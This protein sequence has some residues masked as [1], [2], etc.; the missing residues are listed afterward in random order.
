MDMAGYGHIVPEQVCFPRQYEPDLAQRIAGKLGANDDDKVVLKLCNR[1]RAAGVLVVPVDELDEV[2]EEILVLPANP[3]AWFKE[4]LKQLA[5]SPAGDFGFQW[6]SFEEQTRHWWA[7]EC[8][9]FVAERW[10]TSM[11]TI[12]EG[13]AYDGTMRVG[14]ALRRKSAKHGS[15]D[16]VPGDK[17]LDGSGR[18]AAEIV[19]PPEELEVE[20]LGGYWKLPKSDMGSSHLRERVISAAR[21]SGTALVK[22]AHLAEVYAALGDSVQ[23]LFGGIEPNSTMLGEHY[24]DQPELAAYLT[25]RLAISSREPG[26]IR[27]MLYDAT[28][29]TTKAAQ[30]LALNCVHSFIHR[31]N[32]VFEA[33]SGGGKER[34]ETARRHFLNS[35][36]FLPTNANT[37]YLL[38]MAALELGQ[39][40]KAIEMMSKSLLLDPDFKAPYINLGVAFLRMHMYEHAV[41]ISDAC[42]ARHP[43]TPQCQYHIGVASCQLALFLETQE[44]AGIRL[45]AAES[46]EYEEHRARSLEAF[47]QARQS[48]EGQRRKP[49]VGSGQVLEPPAPWLDVDEKMIEAMDVSGIGQQVDGKEVRPALVRSIGLPQTAGWRFF[50]WRT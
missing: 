12:R 22:P 40:E 11:P 36:K 2:L 16:S 42:L 7:N 43:H 35:L 38:G 10:C 27:K 3:E 46:I 33:R 5:S 1:S 45:V 21:T 13:M 29:T 28:V 20:W 44:V 19:P 18:V 8:P 32:G 9:S 31:G 14:F 15:A 17:H 49:I 23:Q 37:L 6:G 26:R 41:E 24:R 39:P 34:W 25:A 47:L 50:G 30:G 4:K 48:E